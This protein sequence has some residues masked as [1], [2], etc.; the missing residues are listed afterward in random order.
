MDAMLEKYKPLVFS[1]EYNG[2]FPLSRAITFPNDTTEHWQGDRAYGASL[3]ALNISAEK[4]GYKLV[5]VEISLDLF[6]IRSDILN[7]VELHPL[8]YWADCVGKTQ[9]RSCK[10]R[11]SIMLDYEV[12]LATGDVEKAKEAAKDICSE[13]MTQPGNG[14]D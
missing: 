12:Y 13:V 14:W 7:G 8:E 3:K 4:H 11:E 2:N 5:M 10:G 1:V 9:H 6:F